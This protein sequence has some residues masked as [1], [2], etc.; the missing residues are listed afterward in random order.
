MEISTS[1]LSAKD[2]I[3][4]IK[5]LNRTNTSYIHVDVMDG[6]FVQDKQFDTYEKVHSVSLVSEKKLDIHLMV[7]NPY[8]YVIQY[9]NMDIEFITIHIESKGDKKRVIDEIK[10]MGYKV[11]I[12]IKPNTD[13]KELEKYLNDIDMILVMSV[14]PGKGGQK[15]IHSSVEKIN[16]IKELIGDRNIL[17]EVDG[18]INDETI[19]LVQDVDIAVVGS[20][21]INSDNYYK[22]I[23]VLVPS[24][25][26]E[27]KE[28]KD[29]SVQKNNSKFGNF[30]DCLAIL[31][32]FL[33][34]LLLSYG[35][36]SIFFGHRELS[37]WGDGEV[38]R[39]LSAFNVAI[40]DGVLFFIL[41]IIGYF[42][43]SLIFLGGLL[44]F[45]KFIISDIKIVINRGILYVVA[46]LLFILMFIIYL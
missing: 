5:K 16:S 25:K 32:I 12:A 46:L 33:F 14:E 17:L 22:S 26:V 27:K 35:I 1:V 28:E 15:F 36:F 45:T 7:D 23:E 43:F 30:F 24:K 4:A 42:P 13:V 38:V 11:G 9:K 39:G 44:F 10:S 40:N 21:I 31:F 19:S 41:A 18:G 2:R 3:E 29:S 20:Y 37:I 6:K 34:V 8:E